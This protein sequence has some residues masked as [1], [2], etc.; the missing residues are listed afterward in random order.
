MNKNIKF[1]FIGGTYRGCELLKFLIKSR[2]LPAFCFILKEDDHEVMNY[3]AQAVSLL[4]KHH[5]PFFL[6]KKLS[7]EDYQYIQ[8]NG[9]YDFGICCGWRTIIN[10]N[11]I[12]QAI[13][14]GIVAGHDSLLPKYRGFAPV[15][16][17]MI[18]GE[19][20]AGITL[21]LINMGEIDSGRVISQKKI[22][23]AADDYA[24]DVY[25]KV[26]ISTVALYNDFIQNYKK[27][28]VK[29][30]KQDES[31]ATYT[32]KR[33]PD[34]GKINWQSSSIEIMNLIRGLAHPYP[35]AYCLY[36]KKIYHIRKAKFGLNNKKQYI[37]KIT[38]RVI[39][40]NKDGIEVLCGKG[41][42]LI[43]IWEDKEAGRIFC[44]SE[45]VKTISATLS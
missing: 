33:I 6:R 27:G 14:F 3:S 23:I 18:N 7:S 44:P 2:N 8:Q 22:Q 28:T 30:Y 24:I 41:S 5:I 43:Q 42:V 10:F 32:C 35:G 45:I 12:S 11:E 31:K 1:F 21:F 19:K 16:W 39:S 29:T 37:G 34:D 15:N 20:E 17:A 26:S 25:E 4:Q 13:K 38:G 36:Q 9:V 40:Y